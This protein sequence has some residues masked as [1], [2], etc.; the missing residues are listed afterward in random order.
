MRATASPLPRNANALV[1]AAKETAKDMPMF[2]TSPWSQHRA[3]ARRG[4]RRRKP[5]PRCRPAPSPW[6]IIT[7]P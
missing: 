5:D 6:P 3:G 1:A 7:S 4:S 2:H